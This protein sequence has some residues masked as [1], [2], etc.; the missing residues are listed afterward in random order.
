MNKIELQLPTLHHK[1]AAENFKTEFFENQEHEIP[2][3]AMLDGMEYEQW[4][5]FN[6]NNRK[7]NTVSRGWVAATTFFAVRKLDN[8]IIGI[9]DI[10]HNLENEFLA[11]FGGHI[12]YSV[13]PSERKKGYA[14]D[15]LKMG[16]DYAKSL[17]IKEVM[18]AC[19]SDN[20][21][22]IRTIEKCG[23]IF[24]ESKYYTD[25][26]IPYFNEKII[27]IYYKI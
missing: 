2:G 1:A 5:T 8:K 21:A 26:N 24:S 4:L 22:S 27:N 9:I 11:Q 16:L 3:S 6:E 13:C 19:F 7:E 17:N 15:I 18:I 14:T 10:R 25:G 23:G 20:I 12:G